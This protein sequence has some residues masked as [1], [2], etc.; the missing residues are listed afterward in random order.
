MLDTQLCPTLCDPIDYSPPSSSVHGILQARILECV[1][2]SFS[3][4]KSW[5][6][7]WKSLSHVQLFATPWTVYSTWN[8]PGKNMGVGCHFLL[9]GVFSTQG[10]NPGLLHCRQILYHLHHQGSPLLY[11]CNFH[12]F[13]IFLKFYH[14][15]DKS[16]QMVF[17]HKLR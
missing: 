14:K 7:K 6:W 16:C 12:L 5:K 3:K 4:H 13:L 15:N 2:I 10:L 9:Q 8:S 1:A 17:I 11:W